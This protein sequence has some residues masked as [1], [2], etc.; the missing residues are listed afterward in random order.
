MFPL[1]YKM[2]GYYYEGKS[3]KIIIWKSTNCYIRKMQGYC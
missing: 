3:L 1:L 2:Q